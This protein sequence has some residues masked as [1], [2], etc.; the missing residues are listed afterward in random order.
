M[1][2][3]RLGLAAA[4]S[5]V[6]CMVWQMPP[7][8]VLAYELLTALAG[9][10][11]LPL[12][13][14]LS[15][16]TFEL[17]RRWSEASGGIRLPEPAHGLNTLPKAVRIYV[18]DDDAPVMTWIGWRT[19]RIGRG[20]DNLDHAQFL[21]AMQEAAEQRF[22]LRSHVFLFATIGNPLYLTMRLFCRFGYLVSWLLGLPLAVLLTVFS[23]GL[24]GGLMAGRT[25]AGITNTLCNGIS[26]VFLRLSN[27]AVCILFGPLL[28]W[29]DW[30]VDGALRTQ[31]LGLPLRALMDKL[32]QI[33]CNT[34]FLR[35]RPLIFRAPNSLRLRWMEAQRQGTARPGSGLER[36][37][38]QFHRALMPRQHAPDP[39]RIR[40]AERGQRPEAH[41]TQRETRRI[42]ISGPQHRP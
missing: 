8:A 29:G 39:R 21:C 17:N 25:A 2:Y 31:G 33:T 28:I 16:E 22:T 42:R 4:V 30:E 24:R 23:G 20:C 37:E 9:E 14:H 7:A 41:R 34:P 10:Y 19:L 40:L 36:V 5:A 12:L 6:L 27:A 18:M 11:L 38:P 15:D 13:V 1:K 3:L 32:Q 35:E 26:R